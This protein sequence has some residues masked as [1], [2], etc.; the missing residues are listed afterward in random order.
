[1]NQPQNTGH[2]DEGVALYPV[3]LDG[4]R[5]QLR[6][7]QENDLDDCMAVVGDCDVTRHLN[8]DTRSRDQQEALL[9]SD[10]ARSKLEPRPDYYL[11]V[12]ERDSGTMIGFV[13]L[14]LA[15]PG[16]A[17]LGY[18]VRKAAWGHGYATE[19]AALMLNFGY[20]ALGLHRIQAACG[21]DNLASQRVLVKLG[22]RRESHMRHHVF[23]NGAWR[24]SLLYSLLDDEWASVRNA[25][26][27][28]R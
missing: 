8:F 21:P 11:A 5:L 16:T 28:H 1:M 25:V 12:V 17:E 20:D 14:G 6:E 19:A 23:T 15:R 26:P 27:L 9:A 7:F 4:P 13:W 2:L 22:F 18:A 24:Y 10:I 3:S